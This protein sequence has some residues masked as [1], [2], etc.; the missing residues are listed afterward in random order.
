VTVPYSSPELRSLLDAAIDAVVL[1]DETGRIDAFSPAAESLFGYAA[2]QVIGQHVSLLLPEPRPRRRD[3][4]TLAAAMRR[5]MARGRELVG[6][7]QDGSTFPAFVSVARM[8]AEPARFVAFGRD[9]TERRRFERNRELQERLMRMT[10]LATVGEMA[11]GVAHELNQP[12]TAIAN[13]AQAGERLLGALADPP[14]EV[15]VALQRITTQAVRAGEVIQRLRSLVRPQSSRAPTDI[16][17]L[18]EELSSL[19]RSDAKAHHVACRMELGSD[20]PAI[21]ADRVQ[22]QQ[23]LL[24]LFHNA[25]EAFGDSPL[26]GR[27]VVVRSS[28]AGSELEIHVVDNGPGVTA[29]MVPRLFHPFATSKPGGTGLGL[30][31]SQTIVRAHQGSL[32]HRP[33]QP[34]GAVFSIRIPITPSSL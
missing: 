30:T 10:R 19:M 16:N 21:E 12:L 23:V 13:Y 20:L 27:E 25:V 24:N 6:R 4:R 8:A 1:F 32:T 2:A 17:A 5:L 26:D 31:V 3:A 22:L 33:N 9:L 14:A 28:Q 15:R 11:A 18:I 7:R 29:A 34:T